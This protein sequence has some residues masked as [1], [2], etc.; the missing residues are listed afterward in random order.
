[1]NM[2]REGLVTRLTATS[3]D[4]ITVTIHRG[5]PEF[6][7]CL[8]NRALS[9]GH[10]QYGNLIGKPWTDE[11]FIQK[12]REMGQEFAD[13]YAAKNALQRKIDQNQK[14]LEEKHETSTT[15]PRPA[16]VSG[17]FSLC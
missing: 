12:A 17:N 11:T 7:H 10:Y 5:R 9:R 16:G 14:E 2:D 4:E 1:M 15:V 13:A 8:L 6:N 3:K